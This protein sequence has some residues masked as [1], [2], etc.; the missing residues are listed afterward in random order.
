M[1]RNTTCVYETNVMISTLST[2][3][4]ALQTRIISH[5]LVHFRDVRAKQNKN[6]LVCCNAAQRHTEQLLMP[7]IKGAIPLGATITV[8]SRSV[9]IHYINYDSESGS[10]VCQTAEQGCRLL[11]PDY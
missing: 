10:T 1:Y 7:Q 9:Q 11:D 3:K 5:S 6:I 4:N 8:G 2:K